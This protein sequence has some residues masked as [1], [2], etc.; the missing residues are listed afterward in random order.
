MA[1][2][3]LGH[4]QRV[5]RIKKL[6]SQKPGLTLAGNGYNGIGVPDCVRSGSEAAAE[7]YHR[8]G[9]LLTDAA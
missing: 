3:G 9:I 1:Q 2:Y 4:G 8:V 5:E 7:I 6:V